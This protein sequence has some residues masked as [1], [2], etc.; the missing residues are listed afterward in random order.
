MDGDE[1]LRH[2][3]S[4]DEHEPLRVY[5]DLAGHRFCVFVA[6]RLAPGTAATTLPGFLPGNG[7][8]TGDRA[9]QGAPARRPSPL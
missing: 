5:A 8:Q 3:R 4:A 9:R 7:R 2:D 6:T 1:P